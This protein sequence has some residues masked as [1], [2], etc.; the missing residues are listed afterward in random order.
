MRIE[1]AL[2]I[3]IEQILAGRQPVGGFD[4]KLIA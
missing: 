4:S 3:S 1:D 2:R